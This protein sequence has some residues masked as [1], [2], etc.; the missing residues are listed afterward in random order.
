MKKRLFA[1]LLLCLSLQWGCIA[2]L[3]VD[4]YAYVVNI[5]IERGEILPY[6]YV[7]VLN[8]EAGAGGEDTGSAGNK[9]LTV[10]ESEGENLLEAVQTLS[11]ASPA[12]LNFERTSLLALS[13]ELAEEGDLGGLEDMHFERLKLRENIRFIVAKGEMK[14]VLQGLMSEADPS[15][16]RL[17]ANVGYLEKQEGLL[18]D[19][20]VGEV[21][22]RLHGGVGDGA[23]LYCGIEEGILEEDMAGNE[24][25]PYLG[26]KLLVSGELKTTLG[27]TAVFAGRRMAGVLSG[28]HTMLVNMALGEFTKGQLHFQQDNGEKI[29]VSL[30][31]NGR[32]QKRKEG[33]RVIFTIPLEAELQKPQTIQG[34]TE[35]EWKS[36]LEESLQKETKRVF[37]AVQEAGA[38]IF[39]LGR[40]LLMEYASMTRWQ[41]LDWEQ[42]VKE[43][44]AEFVFKI[45]FSREPGRGRE[46]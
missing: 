17:K 26:G 37:L 14:A 10:M 38:D 31:K 15:M 46:A 33:K 6:R 2:D 22:E 44:E 4:A 28:Q 29:T 32:V 42:A 1:L 19:C 45:A 41:R 36:F 35:G 24:R 3:P 40:V 5:G 23:V 12:Q 11:L 13:R 20:T 39:R 18:R 43:M 21:L 7:F 27:G 16:N 34:M 30:Y 25:Y 9:A 8:Q